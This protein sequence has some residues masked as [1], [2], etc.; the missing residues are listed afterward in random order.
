ML[1]N[2]FL[3]DILEYNIESP[4][5]PYQ[6]KNGS[7]DAIQTHYL[8]VTP[9][10]VK[11]AYVFQTSPQSNQNNILLPRPAVYVAETITPEQAREIHRKLWNLGYAPFLIVLLPNQVRVYN[12]FDFEADLKTNEERGLLVDKP[13]DHE[14]LRDLLADFTATSIDS[15]NIWQSPYAQK[16]DARQRVD[17]RLLRNLEN[18]AKALM[19]DPHNP[20]DIEIAHAL[21]GK[22]IYI[23]FLHDRRIISP[24]WLAEHH[25][26]LDHVLGRNATASGLR[27][28]TEALEARF[29][30]DIFP[31]QFDDVQLQDIHVRLVA[32]VFKGDA[33]VSPTTLQRSIDFKDFEAYDFHYIPIETLST[34]YELFLHAQG[35]G[36]SIGA[37]YTPE[38]LADYVL[39]EI[40]SVK[41]LQRGMQILDPSCGSGVFLVLAY[42][43]LIEH[44]LIARKKQQLSPEELKTL[45]LESIYGVEREPGACNVT[46]LSLILTMLNYVE[47]P[48]LHKNENFKF[49]ALRNSRIFNCD[50]FDDNSLF[51]QANLHFDWV[52]GNPPWIELNNL[53][54]DEEVFAREWIEQNQK[55]RPVARGRVVEA[56]S[57]R[58]GDLVKSNGAIALIHHATS[59]FNK[60]S[61]KYRQRFFRQHQVYRITNFANL[62]SMLFEGRVTAP[63]ATFIY[64]PATQEEPKTPIIHYSP[65]SVNQVVD[66]KRKLWLLTINESEIQVIPSEE[67][68]S[69]EAAVWKFA[70]WGTYRDKRA[71][72][73]L[74]RLF[75]TT[76]SQLCQKMG[77]SKPTEGAQLRDITKWPSNRQDELEYRPE[78]IGISVLNTASLNKRP[79]YLLS[80]PQRALTKKVTDST[81][82]IRKRGGDAGLTITKEPHI[83]IAATW[84]HIIYSEQGFII[85]ARQIGIATNHNHEADYLRALTLYLRSSLVSYYI[86]FQV[87]EWGIFLHA[88]IV[89][90]GA[91]KQIPVP[92]FT[93]EQI[94]QLSQL[95]KA[96][97]DEEIRTLS[98]FVQTDDLRYQLQKKLDE[99]VFRILNIPHNLR[100]LAKEFVETRLPLN[101]GKKA[102]RQLTQPATVDR[103]RAYGE[104]LKDKLD[105]AVPNNMHHNITIYASKELIECIVE[106]HHSPTSF[107]VDVEWV[108]KETAEIFAEI[109]QLTGKWESQWVYVQRG[110]RV[111]NGS[112]IHIYKVPHLIEWTRT[113]ALNDAADI[114]AEILAA[115]EAV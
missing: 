83:Y 8:R 27:Q 43:R 30:G 54:E 59:L 80:I 22:Y 35:E 6:W 58:V 105:D 50:F 95:H 12:A 90:L 56:F 87:P 112:K 74:Q 46:E 44:E 110:L 24:E 111:F 31:L 86:F 45:L 115:T 48:E 57:W 106:I 15:G 73:R 69:G 108:E 23:R 78:L 39:S 11:G 7:S 13:L 107:P 53:S 34:I 72:A 91:V 84:N 52:V 29:N 61:K 65:F 113:Q 17:Q 109:R 55:E 92:E 82:Y 102:V 99:E 93:V 104:M 51:W 41:P 89:T 88:K 3:T 71:I 81:A 49:P 19:D 76:L 66:V 67:A 16:I 28:L 36:R 47:P 98:H 63:A 68:E 64:K 10:E 37:Y 2:E 33:L 101:Q 70:M 18:L 32:S 94:S 62:R 5:S 25:I 21:I 85:P 60:T 14:S 114:M 79:H 40:H 77:W 1:L 9:Q 103:L 4:N 20:L 97:V 38:T 96:L 42:R 26:N 100:I 75:P